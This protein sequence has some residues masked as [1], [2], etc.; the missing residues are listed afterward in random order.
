M[1]VAISFLK[2]PTNFR[3]FKPCLTL[4][5]PPRGNRSAMRLP[6]WRMNSGRRNPAT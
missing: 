3:R 5:H 2:K 4:R 1:R 6:G